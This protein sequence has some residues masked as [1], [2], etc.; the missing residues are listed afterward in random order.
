[1]K[2]CFERIGFECD[3][4]CGEQNP[5]PFKFLN[6]PLKQFSFDKKIFNPEEYSLIIYGT[7]RLRKDSY[8]Y[9]KSFNVKT[10][11]FV[12]GNHF[13]KESEDFV[14]PNANAILDFSINRPESDAFWIIPS[15]EFMIPYL[16]TLRDMKGYVVPH[17]WSPTML[18]D[19]YEKRYNKPA[20]NMIYNTTLC[21]N[22]QIDIY[23]LEPN[24]CLIKTA[25]IPIAASE[26]L[27]KL[28]PTLLREVN[29]YNFPAHK[30]AD[31]IVDELTLGS[32]LKKLARIGLEEVFERCN[33]NE[34]FPIFVSHH[35]KNSLNYLYYEILYYGFPLVHN[36]DDLD[37]CGY[38]YPENNISKCVDAIL[39]AYKYH[40]K[41]AHTYHEKS[42]IYLERV[43]PYHP[44]VGSIWKQMIHDILL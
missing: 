23:V 33:T 39:Y 28:N 1:M 22:K 24:G 12:C 29:V 18:N 6:I 30:E 35:Y 27:N 19:K 42:L 8:I 20:N 26:K 5:K 10:V 13:I 16:E 21:R 31:D 40:N 11:N 2:E 15:Y 34:T 37:G 36:S 41:Q 14:N 17:L 7:R 43:D 3:F 44:S 25:L 32:K 4:L 38:H 9:L